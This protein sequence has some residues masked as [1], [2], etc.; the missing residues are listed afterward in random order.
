MVIAKYDTNGVM[1]WEQH[2]GSADIDVGSAIAV[3]AAGNVVITGTTDGTLPGSPEANAGLADVF[4]AK[5]DTNG[6][7]LWVHQLGYDGADRAARVA[8]DGA[9]NSYVTGFLEGSEY[10]GRPPT[11]FV[12]KYDAN[13]L[14]VWL[15]HFAGDAI[16]VDDSGNIY[17]AGSS[18][19]TMQGAPETSA[20]AYDLF[21][22]KYDTDG[23]RQWIHQLGSASDDY[24]NAIALD[25]SGN[26]FVTGTTYGTLPGAATANAGAGDMFVAKYD[27]DGAKQWVEQLGSVAEDGAASIGVDG[28][29]ISYITGVTGGTM[30][31]SPEVRSDSHFDDMFIAAFAS[32]T[33]VETTTTTQ[34]N[35]TT[36]SDMTA[37]AATSPTSNPG[38]ANGELPATGTSSLPLTLLGVLLVC[39]GLAATVATRRRTMVTAVDS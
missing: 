8:A 10:D 30:P 34:P 26:V 15:Q 37:T 11:T 19:G 25:G 36:T 13:G 22:A 9:G 14:Q 38:Q 5:Y 4:V 21:V 2:L 3:D 20:G 16:A 17:L 1:Q 24:G 32:V 31:G 33:K 28:S 29:G 6:T 18:K 35:A 7:M 39:S 27:S 23:A 12:A